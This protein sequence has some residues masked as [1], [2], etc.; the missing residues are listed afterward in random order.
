MAIQ[1]YLGNT[2]ILE[3]REQWKKGKTMLFIVGPNVF[4]WLL[5]ANDL[6]DNPE[7]DLVAA[8]QAGMPVAV[9]DI[10][11]A[12]QAILEALSRMKARATANENRGSNVG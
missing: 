6:F 2:S 12:Y 9:L 11:K 7:I 10:E 1:E 3:L 8:H 5:C 4:P